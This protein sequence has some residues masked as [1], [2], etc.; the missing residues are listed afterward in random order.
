MNER[1]KEE[2]E[3]YERK[4]EEEEGRPD[5]AGHSFCANHIREKV[6]A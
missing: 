1:K 2:R 3:E 5:Y 4:K 6:G